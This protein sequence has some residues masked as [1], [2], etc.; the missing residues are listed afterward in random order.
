MNESN[1]LSKYQS[2]FRPHHSTLSAL[3]KICDEIL[4]NMDDGENKLYSIFRHTEIYAPCTS[5]VVVYPDACGQFYV[6][7]ALSP[8]IRVK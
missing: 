6:K 2:G 4:N 1:L 5:Y 3:I 8:G 7:A